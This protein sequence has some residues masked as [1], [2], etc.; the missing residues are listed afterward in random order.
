LYARR[1]KKL[2][3]ARGVLPGKTGPLDPKSWWLRRRQVSDEQLSAF[4]E[5]FAK[6]AA[7]ILN[8]YDLENVRA[9]DY[10]VED[11]QPKVESKMREQLGFIPELILSWLFKML[12]T[13]FLHW[14]IDQLLETKAQ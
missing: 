10:I 9:R 11:A 14:L 13:A 6:T 8:K 1:L 5:T 12:L 2:A 4:S 7:N 3:Q